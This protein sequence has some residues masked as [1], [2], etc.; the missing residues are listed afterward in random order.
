MIVVLI[1]IRTVILELKGNIS[2][3]VITIRGRSEFPVEAGGL[4]V[5]QHIK[6]SGRQRKE[7]KIGGEEAPKTSR[8]QGTRVRG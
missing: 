8:A 4:Y 5:F 2:F 6:G 7:V 1:L 3:V